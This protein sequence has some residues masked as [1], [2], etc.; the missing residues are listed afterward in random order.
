MPRVP[1]RRRRFA[2]LLLV[3]VAAIPVPV[4][5]AGADVRPAASR[6]TAH[7]YRAFTRRGHSVFRARV[8]SGRCFTASLT[9]E[10]RDAWRCSTKSLIYDPCFSSSQAPGIVLCP[11][12]PWAGT[13]VQITLTGGLPR[14][15]GAG[16]APSTRLPPWA[17]ELFDGRRC[18]LASGATN[19]I[20]GQR[21]NYFCGRRRDA[22][23]GFPDRSSQPW[24][25]LSAS[26]SASALTQRSS[27]HNAWM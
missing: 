24:T 6:T 11:D 27:V 18:L 25:I 22:L 26:P 16:G 9:A 7:V 3:A 20:E 19:V 8:R 5:A 4:G 15:F 14:R 23:W 12:A 21:L 1:R 17:L 2:W 13:G 10:R